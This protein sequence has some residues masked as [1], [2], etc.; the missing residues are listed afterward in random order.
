[1]GGKVVV[2]VHFHVLLRYG[3]RAGPLYTLLSC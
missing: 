1:M 3:V 2:Q